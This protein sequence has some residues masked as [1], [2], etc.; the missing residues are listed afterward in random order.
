MR[1]AI[2]SSSRASRL[3]VAARA[4]A[5]PQLARAEAV[6]GGAGAPVL[7]QPGEVDVLLALARLDG[8]DLRRVEAAAAAARSS[9]STTCA[10]RVENS[11]SRSRGTPPQLGQPLVRLSPTRRRAC[12]RARRAAEPG[13]GSRRRAGSVFRIGSPSSARHSP[14]LGR[15]RHVGD[16]HVRV[17]V[18][19][20]RPARAVL[21]GGR[22]EARARARGRRRSCRAGSRTPRPR[23]RRAPPATRP[24]GPR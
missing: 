13:R 23:G 18:R 10:R 4:R 11:R 1:A 7:S 16:D 2:A 15:L 9:C 8:R 19:I 24:G 20:L 21:V 12:V 3:A 17:Q 5:A 22:D 14:S 6:L